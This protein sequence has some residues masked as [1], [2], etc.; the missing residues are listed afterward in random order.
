[1][2]WLRLPPILKHVSAPGI[3]SHLRCTQFVN[4]NKALSFSVYKSNANAR[5]YEA[6]RIRKRKEKLLP[7]PVTKPE[8]W[9]QHDLI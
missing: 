5:F 7:K 2:L 4:E 8:G 9:F 6:H 1:M 3:F